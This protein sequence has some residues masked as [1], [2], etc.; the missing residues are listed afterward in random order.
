MLRSAAPSRRSRCPVAALAGLACVLALAAVLAP[1]PIAR[2]ETGPPDGTVTRLAA[3]I[4]NYI[5]NGNTGGS[6]TSVAMFADPV[7]GA[8]YQTVGNA[9]DTCPGSLRE[10]L[11]RLDIDDYTVQARGCGGTKPGGST[12]PNSTKAPLVAVDS[13]DRLLFFSNAAMESFTAASDAVVVVDAVTLKIVATWPLPSEPSPTLTRAI[14]GL[15]W[16]A[17]TDRL[18]VMTAASTTAPLNLAPPPGVE[19]F[20]YDVHAAVSGKDPVPPTWSTSVPGCSYPLQPAF[21]TASAY[22]SETLP[23]VY[24]PCGLQGGSSASP[25]PGVVR[26][27]LAGGVPDGTV[28]A[29]AAPGGTDTFLFDSGGDRG[30]MPFQGNTGTSLLTYD[31]RTATFPGKA[32]I[33]N[34]VAGE[35]NPNLNC[36]VYGLDAQ[37][38][39]VVGTGP[40]GMVLV[41]GRRTPLAPG[42]VFTALGGPVSYNTLPL[43]PPTT[44]HRYRR[45]L[46][47]YFVG[48]GDHPCQSPDGTQTIPRIAVFA[49]RLPVTQNP[50]A[51]SVD[52]NT[53]SGPVPPDASTVAVYGANAAGAASHVNLVG[54][55]GGAAN[56]TTGGQLID[57]NTLPLGSG[58]RNVLGAWVQQARLAGPTSVADATAFGDGNGT[59]ASGL[60]ACTGASTS[61]TGQNPPGGSS[62]GTAQQWPY[63]DAVCF[64]PSAPATQ[65]TRQE[66]FYAT[67]G[68]DQSGQPAQQQVPGS[69]KTSFADA[70]CASGTP[71]KGSVLAVTHL[72]SLSGS[73]PDQQLRLGGGTTTSSASPP[74]KTVTAT[75][76][77]ASDGFSL[78]VGGAELA[79]GKVSQTATAAAAGVKGSAVASRQ[80]LIGDVTVTPAGGPPVVICAG[81]CAGSPGAVVEQINANLPA[82]MQVLLPQPDLPFG[83]SKLDSN[84]KQTINGSPGGYLA[85]VQ[86]S[87]AQQYGDVQFNGVPASDGQATLLPALR[88]VSYYDAGPLTST[89]LDRQIMDLAAVETDAEL[90]IS[91]LPGLP[92]PVPSIDDQKQ[93]AGAVPPAGYFVPGTPGTPAVDGTAGGD[94]GLLSALSANGGTATVGA[95]GPRVAGLA[96]LVA[97]VLRRSFEGLGWLRRHPAE[98]LRVFALLGLLACPLLVMDRRRR[99][100][101]DVLA[102]PA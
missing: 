25:R 68:S 98:A 57:G 20:S 51:G 102:S 80:I 6:D 21:G 81:T 5:T 53:Q 83:G 32:A 44:K 56:N 77:A 73:A 58:N 55:Y 79:I 62:A 29:S 59:S 2:A 41:D 36:V 43:L 27:G 63:R 8:L 7:N 82:T 35:N 18:L 87:R 90:G 33:S 76:S 26:L 11:V 9:D 88:V 13:T 10:P 93:A 84:G 96:G 47:N 95:R 22:Q 40:A 67:Q 15:S 38:G 75:T 23:Y 97:G 42:S 17:T 45:V 65:H 14:Y 94:T 12:A 3:D 92:G 16:Q 66:G 99:W 91:V 30:F 28:A 39:R 34:T 24:V 61:C 1:V 46:V 60:A 69:D 71:A 19:L 4:P 52:D 49:D 54:S 100:V 101:R 74:G 70:D 78:T 89:Q 50:P 48:G 37:T 64:G 85:V 31:G 86:A 72:S